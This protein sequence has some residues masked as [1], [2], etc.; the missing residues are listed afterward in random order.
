MSERALVTSPVGKLL[1]VQNLEVHFPVTRGVFLPKTV[2]VVRAVDGISFDLGRGETLGLVGESGCGKSTVGRALARLIPAAG[3]KV[4]FDGEDILRL[5]GRALR[6]H[7]PNLQMIF[8]DPFASLNP[9]MTVG[10][11]IAE[12]L[13]ANDYGSPRVIEA[14][15]REL[16]ELCG[17]SPRDVR[18]FPHEFSGGQRQRVAIAR[19]IA[20]S[21]AFI[22]ADEPLSAL[23]V[24]IRAQ[25][26]NLLLGLQ[27]TFGLTMLFISHDMA[28]VRHLA[29]RVAVMYLGKLVEVAPAKAIYRQPVHPYTQALNAAIPFPDP[30]VSRARPP[31]VLSGEVPSPTNPPTGCR[32]HTRCPL[33]RTLPAD[34]QLACRQR[35]PELRR[36]ATDHVAACHW[37]G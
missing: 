6:R 34:R 31:A 21:P 35:E 10:S 28:A 27:R 30:E 22:V 8:Q 23:D 20:L 14:R 16:V 3:G 24:S 9:R 36:V 25:I 37:T 17:L 12:P 32:F 4:V 26:M 18:R 29:D 1:S 13:R 33:Y 15:V 11:L 7:R 5:Q 2:G 19:A